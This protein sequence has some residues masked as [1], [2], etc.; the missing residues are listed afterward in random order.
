M[1]LDTNPYRGLVANISPTEFEVLCAETMKAYAKI[2]GLKE[3]SILHNQKI[4]AHDGTYQIDNL[5]AFT[6]LSVRFKVLIECKYYNR[7]IE[8]DE[9]ML[10]QSK[11]DSSDAQKGIIMS[12]S[13]FQSGAVLYAKEHGIALL[14]VI[15]ESIFHI[16]NSTRPMNPVMAAM[17][18]EY[19]K[20]LPKYRSMLW[21]YEYDMPIKTIYPTSEMIEKAR[22]EV[23]ELFHA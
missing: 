4:T 9:V 18:L 8:R 2:E 23:K 11:I 17:E 12:T 19:R 3:F 21:D 1:E 7:K 5:A 16:N 13:S 10:L 15:E 20:R 14:Q 22:N 6:A